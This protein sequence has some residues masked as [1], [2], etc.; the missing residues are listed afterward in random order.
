MCFLSYSPYCRVDN[1]SKQSTTDT[2]YSNSPQQTHITVIHNRHPTTVTQQSTI[3]SQLQQ[4]TTDSNS[5]LRLV[6]MRNR[7]LRM[8]RSRHRSKYRL[9][10]LRQTSWCKLGLQHS[11]AARL[12]TKRQDLRR[13]YCKSHASIMSTRA[14]VAVSQHLKLP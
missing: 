13:L 8:S 3:N 2:N 10:E 7:L 9:S 14:T 5:P 12:D 11:I 1:Y 6:V 4:S